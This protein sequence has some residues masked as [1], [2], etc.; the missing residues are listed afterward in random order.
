MPERSH[1][2]RI[3][4]RIKVG[5]SKTL[6]PGKI[7]LLEGIGRQGSIAAAAREMAMSYRR[8]WLLVDDLNH[9]FRGPLVDTAPGER[10]GSRLTALG[11]KVV[12]DYRAIEVKTEAA[13]RREIAG[14]KKALARH[15]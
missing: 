4:I 12:A 15:G 7:A 10:Q 14:L 8:A 5:E 1:P 2:F 11:L 6:G 9:T 13:C 3:S